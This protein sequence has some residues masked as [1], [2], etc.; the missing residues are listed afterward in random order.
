MNGW[1]VC[2]DGALALQEDE[3]LQRTSGGSWKLAWGRRLLFPGHCLQ[4]CRAGEL[5]SLEPLILFA[6]VLRWRGAILRQTE[7]CKQMAMDLKYCSNVYYLC[8]IGQVI[9]LGEP[10]FHHVQNGSGVSCPTEVLED[11]G[12]DV[13]SSTMREALGKEWPNPPL[14]GS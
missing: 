2:S 11:Q 12:G 13:K 1:D 6:P 9:P 8:D 7:L 3:G 4:G 5:A 10:W 14:P